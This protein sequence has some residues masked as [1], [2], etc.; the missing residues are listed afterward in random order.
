M[1]IRQFSFKLCGFDLN[2]VNLWLIFGL[3]DGPVANALHTWINEKETKLFNFIRKQIFFI[4]NIK[5]D[6]GQE[7]LNQV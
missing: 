5:K 6:F 1:S 3:F 4:F 2:E 7:K